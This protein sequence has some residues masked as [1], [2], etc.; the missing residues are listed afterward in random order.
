MNITEFFKSKTNFQNSIINTHSSKE[1]WAQEMNRK[2]PKENMHMKNKCVKSYSKP[3]VSREHEISNHNA[4]PQSIKM[5]KLQ[6]I[7]HMM[8][9]IES[10]WSF[11]YF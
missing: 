4:M 8:A 9:N 3:P 5:T 6:K 10:N 11:M 7:N 1:K 2:F